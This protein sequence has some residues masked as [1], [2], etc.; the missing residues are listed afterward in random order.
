MKKKNLKKWLYVAAPIL[1]CGVLYMGSNNSLGT[2]LAKSV[3]TVTQTM[4]GIATEMS[5][6][7]AVS[8]VTVT[9]GSVETLVPTQTMVAT[10]T[11][12]ENGAQVPTEV[13]TQIETIVP[14]EV[15]T[16]ITV[17]TVTKT[18][19]AT[20]TQTRTAVSYTEGFSGGLVPNRYTLIEIETEGEVDLN[21]ETVASTMMATEVAKTVTTMVP[22]QVPTV[23]STVVNTESAVPTQV[24]TFVDGVVPT[25]TMIMQQTMVPTELVTMTE[26]VIV[27]DDGKNDNAV[28]KQIVPSKGPVVSEPQPKEGWKPKTADEKERASYVYK[29]KVK[30]IKANKSVS[31]EPA[32]QGPLCIK[33]MKNALSKDSK[34]AYTYNIK[35][36]ADKSAK[37]PV[38]EVEK[39]VQITMSIP[40][41]LLKDGRTFEMICVSKDGKTYK[42]PAS[43]DEDGNL[44]FTTK[45]FYAYALT[46]KDA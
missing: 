12:T 33:A 5:T 7:T 18:L 46:Y 15:S 22:T 6:Q 42:I 45:Y 40:K 13:E 26:T 1:W 24:S 36:I 44:N 37:M 10:V 16:E 27:T 43:V 2:V 11:G 35:Y 17:P 39:P 19:G 3:T 28:I 32:M 8:T 21:T 23:I 4:T 41:A 20:I 9:N 25:E 34:I 29:G 31:I 14:T 38:Y 30:V